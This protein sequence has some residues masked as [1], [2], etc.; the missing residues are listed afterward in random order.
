M[1][2]IFTV[3]TVLAGLTSQ[4]AYNDKT[5]RLLNVEIHLIRRSSRIEARISNPNKFA[6]YDVIASCD[7]RDRRGRTVASNTLTIVDAIQA[8]ATRVIPRVEP[9]GW[10][11][12]ATTADCM[13]IEAKRLP[14]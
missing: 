2:Q 1:V 12:Q 3:A 6:V 8:N 9:E 14:D 5:L 13:S 7:F 10:P 11:E 4:P